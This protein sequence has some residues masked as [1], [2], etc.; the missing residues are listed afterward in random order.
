MRVIEREQD[1]T[2]G[3][4]LRLT[5]RAEA[6]RQDVSSFALKAVKESSSPLLF[7]SRRIRTSLS[8]NVFLSPSRR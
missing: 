4:R 7:P 5:Y 6:F 8:Y 3:G 2:V 1:G